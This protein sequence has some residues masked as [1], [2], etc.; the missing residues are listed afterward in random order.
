MRLYNWEALFAAYIVGISRAPFSPGVLD[1]ALFAAGGAE[2]VTAIDPAAAFRGR[3]RSIEAGLK[4]MRDAGYEDHVAFAQAH[5]APVPRAMALPADI[6]ILTDACVARCG[7]ALGLVQGEMI[8]VLRGSGL[9]L[10]PIEA[11]STVLGVR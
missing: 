10:V 2:A 1:C 5:F 4:L 7:P 8:Y 11:A 9:G 6:A 3:Y